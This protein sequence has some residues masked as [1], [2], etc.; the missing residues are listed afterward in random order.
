MSELAL[1]RPASDEPA[2][3]HTDSLPLTVA[4]FQTAFPPKGE[5][6]LGEPETT[7]WG[8]FTS[9]FSGSRRE[10]DKDGCNFVPSRFRLEPDGRQ[11]RR[12]LDRVIARS[13]V[14]LDIET[15]A[16]TG[17][18][19]PLPAV[20]GCRLQAL[21]MAA[22][23][24][25]SHSH[26]PET[27]VRFR[28]ILPLEKEVPPEISAPDIVAEKLGLS[29]VLDRSK[30]NAAALF[31]LPSC[32]YNTLDLHQTTVLPGR[33]LDVSWLTD[34]A[35]ARKAEE[36]RIAAVAHAEAA[37]RLQAKIAAGFNPDDTLIERLRSRFDLDAILRGHG[38]D[39]AGT[40][41]RHP[42]SESGS[43]GADLKVLGGIE[44]VYSHNASDPLHHSN[45]PA[46]C[47]VT[48]ID[49]F[50]ATVIL[51]FSGDRTR[52]LRELAERFNISKAPARKAVAKVI[53]RKVRA[54]ASQAEIEGAAYTAGYLSGLSR[55][56]VEAVA[57][58]AVSKL[59]IA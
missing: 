25:T 43:F 52:A 3:S 37:A 23:I 26:H 7:T 6:A 13:A 55:P 24:Y 5:P 46:W 27:N 11:V 54:Q 15:N 58:W 8:N 41:Y 38:Y 1:T 42:N 39:K 21:G 17:E 45:L 14:V 18:V 57:R 33:P 20:A 34:I 19:P 12:K 48:A 49:A 4:W 30:I 59:E 56:E 28:I 10:G 36:N 31:Y 47:T 44:R 32:P 9:I 53:F 51:D 40:K 35:E 2:V 29:G 50:D 22:V 16:K